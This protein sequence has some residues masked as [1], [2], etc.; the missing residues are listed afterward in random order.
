MMVFMDNF[1]K[2]T[3]ILHTTEYFPQEWTWKK[4]ILLWL[5]TRVVLKE[6]FPILF[7]EI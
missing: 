2:R 4:E 1:E 7:L 6:S 3:H 5:V